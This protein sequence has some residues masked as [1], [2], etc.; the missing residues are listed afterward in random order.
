MKTE[1]LHIDGIDKIILK[2]LMNDARTPILSIARKIGISGAAVHHRLRKLESANLIAGSKF[3]INPKALGFNTLAFVGIHLNSANL[4]SNTI[5]RLKEI[6]EIVESHYTT[7]GYA[8]LVKVFCR[9][10]EHLMTI[11]NQKIQG[12]KGVARTETFI[13][14]E[15]QINR[16]VKL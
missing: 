2:H 16:Q 5:K 14:L 15:Q 1:K 3:I 13:S 4:F 10:N 12:I 7:G 11:L 6:P 9:D 8:V